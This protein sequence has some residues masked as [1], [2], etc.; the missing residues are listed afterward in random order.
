MN[1]FV[2]F[3]IEM[4]HWTFL[5]FIGFPNRVAPFHADVLIVLYTCC[6]LMTALPSVEHRH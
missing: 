6:L 5:L 3:A 1:C 4:N 2:L